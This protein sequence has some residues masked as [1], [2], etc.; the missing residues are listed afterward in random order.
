MSGWQPIETAPKNGQKVLHWR[1]HE[2]VVV[3][4][5]VP[6]MGLWNSTRWDDMPTHWQPLPEPPK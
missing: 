1:P 4:W 3:N 2:G 6:T 5:F